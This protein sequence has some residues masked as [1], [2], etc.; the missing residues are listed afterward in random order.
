M[1]YYPRKYHRF[2]DSVGLFEVTVDH[3]FIIYYG[4]HESW[5]IRNLYTN[6]ISYKD[7]LILEKIY[8]KEIR[9]QI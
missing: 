9:H 6:R 3:I 8:N 2:Y 5:L 4:Y 1:K 7:L